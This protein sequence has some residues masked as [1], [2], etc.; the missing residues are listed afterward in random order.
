MKMLL[1]FW[2]PCSLDPHCQ[3][4]NGNGLLREA[5]GPSP[6]VVFSKRLNEEFSG[7]T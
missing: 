6:L 1:V 3:K 4:K 7:V 5:E 2:P